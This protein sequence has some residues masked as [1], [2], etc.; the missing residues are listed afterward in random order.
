MYHKHVQLKENGTTIN[1]WWINA[2]IFYISI[3]PSKS[4]VA[5]NQVYCR[6]KCGT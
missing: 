3:V 6:Y 2:L 1:Y 5:Y 4:H